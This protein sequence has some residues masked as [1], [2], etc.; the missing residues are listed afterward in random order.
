MAST[1]S[2][3]GRVVRRAAPA[4]GSISR[5]AAAIAATVLRVPPVSWIVRVRNVSDSDSPYSRFIRPIWNT[6]QPSPTITTPAK[7]GWLA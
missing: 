4:T 3:A 6:S 5:I 2:E 1:S 7:F